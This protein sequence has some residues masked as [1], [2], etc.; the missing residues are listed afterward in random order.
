MH[1]QRISPGLVASSLAVPSMRLKSTG[2]ILRS[3]R[4][5]D[6]DNSLALMCTVRSRTALSG[7]TGDVA[8]QS[9]VRKDSRCVLIESTPSPCT[10]LAD[11]SQLEVV[12]KIDSPAAQYYRMISS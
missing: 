3:H 12:T 1:W 7:L 9:Q 10:P 4:N 11:P 6:Y 2:P 8:I 5:H